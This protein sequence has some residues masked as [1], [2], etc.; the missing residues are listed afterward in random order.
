MRNGHEIDYRAV[1]DRVFP[2][3]QPIPIAIKGRF[4][5]LTNT[6]V[7][8]NTQW[9]CPR[10]CSSCPPP[11]APL[12]FGWELATTAEG[13]LYYLDH[14][15]GIAIFCN[16]FVPGNRKPKPI[17][18]LEA[19]PAPKLDPKGKYM[20]S[21]KMRRK[22]GKG[23]YSN[24]LVPLMG[25]EDLH[26]LLKSPRREVVRSSAGAGVVYPLFWG[27]SRGIPQGMIFDVQ[28]FVKSLF[29]P[30]RQSPNG[31]FDSEASIP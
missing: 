27:H 30:I 7:F 22:V 1:F 13:A 4:G 5:G 18:K 28:P 16:S 20:Q 2:N 9:C 15:R 26:N 19:K 25:S 3:P 10:S 17:P 11:P 12:P 8:T 6:R 23:F 29:C 24:L 21:F 14:N 31:F